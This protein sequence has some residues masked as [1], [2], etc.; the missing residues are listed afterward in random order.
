MKQI[1]LTKGK[2]ALVDDEDYE[3]IILLNRKWHFHKSGYATIS[4]SKRI[5]G[6][7]K[8]SSVKM[9]RFVMNAENGQ[10]V[11]HK[12]GDRL[13]NQ[14][15]NLRFCST[16]ENSRNLRKYDR[17]KSGYK[18]VSLCRNKFQ[19]SIRVN[20]KQVYLGLFTCPIEAADTYNKAAIFYFGEFANL[21]KIP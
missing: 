8:H 18:G 16:I 10:I 5:N 21:N 4:T 13:N 6:V 19:S 15:S 11:D 20:K 9:H 17:N 2:F 14:K 7:E 12:D 3:R 1:P